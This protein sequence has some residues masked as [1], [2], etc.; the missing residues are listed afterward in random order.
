MKE[1]DLII[2]KLISSILQYKDQEIMLFASE[3]I[4]FTNTIVEIIEARIDKDA[5]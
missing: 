4:V 1:H 2:L 3:P 5:L